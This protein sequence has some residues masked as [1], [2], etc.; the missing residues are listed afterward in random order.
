M[1]EKCYMMKVACSNKGKALAEKYK[2]P[3]LEASSFDG[4]NVDP[5]F[6]QLS[7]MILAKGFKN[8]ADS[9][10]KGERINPKKQ[11]QSG[12]KK[13]CCKN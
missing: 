10:D 2:V 13:K 12:G 7:E 9:N 8:G 4:T 6:Q 3:F 1:S 11:N 5:A